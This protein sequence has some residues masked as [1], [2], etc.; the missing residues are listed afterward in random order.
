MEF[1]YKTSELTMI[2]SVKTLIK[3]FQSVISWQK[4]YDLPSERNNKI[5][6]AINTSMIAS[7]SFYNMN[8]V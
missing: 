6:N 7:K 2:Q 4:A 5:S 8:F 3:A 1:M